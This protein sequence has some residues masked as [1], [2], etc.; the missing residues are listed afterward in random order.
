MFSLAF[1]FDVFIRIA[2]WGG[3]LLLFVLWIYEFAIGLR[4]ARVERNLLDYWFE[5]SGKSLRHDT[6][7]AQPEQTGMPSSI[8]RKRHTTTATVTLSKPSRKSE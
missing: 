5:S 4:Q 2:I 7:P 1:M 6:R 3:L 8:E